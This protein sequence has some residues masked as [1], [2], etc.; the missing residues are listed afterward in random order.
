MTREHAC[1]KIDEAISQMDYDGKV[2]EYS[3]YGNGHVNDTFLVI[4]EH[5]DEKRSKYLLQRIN[6]E[7]FKNPDQ[8]MKNIAGVTSFLRDKVLKIGGDPKRETLNVI[9]T[10]NGSSYYVD[11]IGCYWR[12]YIFIDDTICYEY[13]EKAEDFYLSG[14]AFGNYQRLLA[15]YPAHTLYET[16]KDFH[17]TKVRFE[18]LKKAIREDACGRARY[19]QKEIEFA[20]AREK[21]A[22]ILVDMQAKGELPIRVTH[23]DT[24]FNNILFDKKTK[25]PVC[26]IDLDTIMPGLSVYDFGDS[27]RFGAS[28]G[29]EDEK[30]LSKVNFDL[31]LYEAYV[32]G[33]IEGTAGSLTHSELDMLPMGAKLMTFE[34][35]IR[36][37]TDYLEGDVYFKID[38]EDHNLDRCR[39][40][41]KL[42][43]DMEEK[44][45]IMKEIVDKYR[46]E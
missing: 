23:N 31:V 46:S 9:P 11:S 28:T 26:I 7:V 43:S 8:L 41:F 6:H 16:I 38:R 32:K 20:L 3:R 5:T 24:K 2:I 19:V 21:D 18:K 22:N 27:I 44:F 15:D 34:C 1:A 29:A 13:V 35:G 40:Q 12:S 17:N 25:K 36:F 39:T 30:D 10:K 4:S 45:D 14:V 33:F 42:V 37:L